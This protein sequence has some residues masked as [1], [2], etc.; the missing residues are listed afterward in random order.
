LS[1]GDIPNTMGRIVTAVI[2]AAGLG[3]RVRE[4]AGDKPKELLLVGGK[5]LIQVVVEEAVAAGLNRIAVVIRPGKES[6][7]EWLLAN[8][9][10][11]AELA[12]PMQQEPL[13][14][15]DAVAHARRFVGGAPFAL[16]LPDQG[17]LAARSATRQLLSAWQPGPGIWSALVQIPAMELPLFPGAR[18][19]HLGSVLDRGARAVVDIPENGNGC[20]LRAIGRTLLSPEIFHFF[21]DGDE[22]LAAIYRRSSLPHRAVVLDGAPWDVGTTA[23]YRHYE[24]SIAAFAA[25]CAS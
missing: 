18:T 22:Q 2:P 1:V 16:L 9:P 14:A 12:F 7:R 6:I 3:T 13:G 21:K 8:R 20:T 5:P 25:G 10:R 17:I 11:G 24:A 4:I 23:G 19:L 15:A